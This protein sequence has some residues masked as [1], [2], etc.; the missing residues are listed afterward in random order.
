MPLK[1]LKI[2]YIEGIDRIGE[3]FAFEE[4]TGFDPMLQ[5]KYNGLHQE[6][7]TVDTKPEDI[8]H[9]EDLLLTTKRRIGFKS[10]WR[11]LPK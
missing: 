7:F 5:V 8:I 2:W 9:I 10:G 1:S 3:Y 11:R 4:K 6:I